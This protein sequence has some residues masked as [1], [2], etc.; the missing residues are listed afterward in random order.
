MH[1]LALEFSAAPR[2]QSPRTQI[3]A[4][5]FRPPQPAEYDALEEMTID[6]FGVA[7]FGTFGNAGGQP[8]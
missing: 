6:A 2:V 1:F 5:H 3:M 4:L 7:R 8:R